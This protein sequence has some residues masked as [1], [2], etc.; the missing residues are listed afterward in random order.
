MRI[1]PRPEPAP[2]R[3]P[4]AQSANG[5]EAAFLGEMLNIAMPDT[6]SGAFGGGVGESQFSSFLIEQYADILAQ[7][8]D[9][10]LA[11]RMERKGA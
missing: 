1:D 8:L 4:A 3:T 11:A 10:G 2:T 7:R 5:L 9:L 6:S